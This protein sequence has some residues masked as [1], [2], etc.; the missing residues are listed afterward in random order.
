[1]DRRPSFAQRVTVIYL[2]FGI[3][4]ILTSDRLVYLI[5]RGDPELLNRL[6]GMKGASFVVLS[7]LLLY[8][9]IQR[10]DR[11]RTQ[12]MR[13]NEE[14]LARFSALCMVSKEGV[15]DYRINDDL[16][17]INEQMQLFLGVQQEQVTNFLSLQSARIHPDDRPRVLRQFHDLMKSTGNDWRSS[18]RYQL[19]DGSWADFMCRGYL[20]RDDQ[21]G[22]PLNLIYSILDVT[23]INRLRA[24]QLEQEL[25]L[26]RLLSQ[27]VVQAQENEKNRWAE[28]LHDNVG[29]I[30]TVSKLLLEQI[31]RDT[32]HPMAAKGE[33]LVLSA[34]QE[35]RA[36]SASLKPPSFTTRT[37]GSAIE[38]LAED[39]NRV[40]PHQFRVRLD[41]DESTM[42]EEEKLLIYR[43][44][45]E[46]LN[47][48]V[49]YADASIVDVQISEAGNQVKIE[50]RDNGRGF[51]ETTMGKG[52]GLRNMSSRLGLFDGQCKLE[53]EPGQ[54]CV[55]LAS[56]LR[57]G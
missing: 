56:F 21:T 8:F 31:K 17:F 26:K 38:E 10:L 36:L 45:Q 13:Q 27:S 55:L 34:L 5:S 39:I 25:K 32:N 49:K 18:Y 29:Q 43:V 16:A 4:W 33:A 44:V 22:S 19:A 1:M 54:G 41:L 48:I 46:Q 11:S 52:I 3:I 20:I 7:A 14:A 42:G 6:Q 51:D 40:R 23:E 15:I 47:N 30:L 57:K 53:S 28:E 9:L 2:L 50:V 35:I 37:L 12:L 24:Q